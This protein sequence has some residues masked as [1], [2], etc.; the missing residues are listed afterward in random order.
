[1][2][3]SAERGVLFRM[4]G[5]WHAWR[6]LLEIGF[7]RVFFQFF[8]LKALVRSSWAMSLTDTGNKKGLEQ[9]SVLPGSCL[10]IHYE[11]RI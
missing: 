3:P 10:S 11:M 1:M 4:S 6:F 8:S 2:A 5:G 7:E 9:P